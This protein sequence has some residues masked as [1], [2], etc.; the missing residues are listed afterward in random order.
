MIC[1]VIGGAIA[2]FIS[3]RLAR[4]PLLR[5]LLARPR[6]AGAD[7]SE[8]RLFGESEVEAKV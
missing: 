8:W 1:C 2:A 5:P 3:A 7:P 4:L 6:T